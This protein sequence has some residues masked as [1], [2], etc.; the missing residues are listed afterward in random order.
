M[1]SRV[2][3]ALNSRVCLPCCLAYPTD[4]FCHAIGTNLRR[5]FPAF[6]SRKPLRAFPHDR[7]MS[8]ISLR[9][10]FYLAPSA[11]LRPSI[12]RR[13]GTGNVTMVVLWR[14]VDPRWL[15]DDRRRGDRRFRDGPRDLL[16]PY[17][18]MCWHR[19]VDLHRPVDRHHF[20]AHP[21]QAAQGEARCTTSERYAFLHEA[22]PRHGSGISPPP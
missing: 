13:A 15:G 6:R 12:A 5:A 21:C 7:V 1:C 18:L 19:H 16:W 20:T 4:H 10:A 17:L 2:I 11:P 8:G 9:S 14:R 22:E 3:S